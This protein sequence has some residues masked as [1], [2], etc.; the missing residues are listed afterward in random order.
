MIKAKLEKMLNTADGRQKF[1]AELQLNKGDILAV[2]GPSG[3]G[4][5]TLLRMLAGLTEADSGK[6][7]VSDRTW[8]DHTKNIRLPPQ[9]RNAGMVFQ[10]YA[11][12][13][14][15]TVEGNLKFAGESDD[16][17]EELLDT[18]GLLQL[19]HKKPWQL[20]GGQQQRVALARALAQ[21][22]QILLLDEALSALDK[23]LQKEMQELLLRLHKRY[24]MTTILVSHNLSEI[25]TLANRLLVLEKGTSQFYENPITYFNKTED[26]I[27]LKGTIKSLGF[28][29]FILQSGNQIYQ[30]PMKPSEMQELNE[31]DPAEIQLLAFKAIHKK[32]IPD[33]N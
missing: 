23:A 25:L 10:D 16:L 4:K 8:Y 5:T 28:N 33:D 9:K 2:Y 1:S 22:P 19:R 14:N 11:L 3:I 24:N 6:I 17:V 27:T 26:H 30:I 32:N 29:H 12:F 15:M 13:P 18:T 20:S 21:Q 7:I 31:G